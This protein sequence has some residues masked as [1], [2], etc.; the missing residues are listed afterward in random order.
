M[1]ESVE[2]RRG[3]QAEAEAAAAGGLVDFAQY[4]LDDLGGGA[5]RREDPRVVVPDTPAYPGGLAA[6]D[7]AWLEE[8]LGARPDK[9]DHEWAK[10]AYIGMRQ[11]VYQL[12][13]AA[14]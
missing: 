2:G 7:V 9:V 5:P 14:L 3:V 13:G 12:V 8:K 11:L 4:G 6:E 1:P 10:E